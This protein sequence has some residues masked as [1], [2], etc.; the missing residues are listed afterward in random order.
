MK[1]IVNLLVLCLAVYLSALILPGIHLTTAFWPVVGTAAVIGVLN[2]LI[3]PI[4][5]I[6]T[7]PIN[8]LT[9]G[10][11]SL[12]INAAMILI[13][14]GMIDDKIFAVNGFWAAFWFS[15]LMTIISNIT[16]NL[17]DKENNA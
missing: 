4:L 14:D 5:N 10:L 1:F 15:I 8:V 3:R 17:I 13:A 7:I 9:L 12:I 6:L 11:F 16:H 2:A